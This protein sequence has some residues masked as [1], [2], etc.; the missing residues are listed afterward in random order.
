MT[1]RKLTI[2][3]TLEAIDKHRVGAYKELIRRGFHANAVDMK[4]NKLIRKDY[5][6]CGV[7][8]RVP[9]LT[10][11]G[12]AWL[13]SDRDEKAYE[14]S[15]GL[16]TAEALSAQGFTPEQRTQTDTPLTYRKGLSDF[17]PTQTPTQTQDRQEE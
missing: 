15:V 1:P 5:L 13:K 4:F 9:W 17:E 6:E 16:E 7:S 3:E 11:K 2:S 12:E 14:E 10:R 8:T